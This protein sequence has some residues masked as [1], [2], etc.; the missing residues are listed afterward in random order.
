MLMAKITITRFLVRGE[1]RS[2]KLYLAFLAFWLTTSSLWIMASGRGGREGQEGKYVL[3]DS[4]VDSNLD[5]A[6]SSL[7]FTFSFMK[8]NYKRSD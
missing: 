7:A 3:A 1:T 5:F 2:S 6:A 8:I 4:H